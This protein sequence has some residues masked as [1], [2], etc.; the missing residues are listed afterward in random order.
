MKIS[1]FKYYHIDS[2]TEMSA[3]FKF[4]QRMDLNSG[5]KNKRYILFIITLT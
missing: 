1:N 5:I 4:I 3:M 2:F